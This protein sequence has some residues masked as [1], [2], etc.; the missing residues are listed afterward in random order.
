MSLWKGVTFWAQGNPDFALP[1][2]MFF[3]L[4]LINEI[5]WGLTLNIYNSSNFFKKAKT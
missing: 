5:P 1:L 2:S 4:E 3:K